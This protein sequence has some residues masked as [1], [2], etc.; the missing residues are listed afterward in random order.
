V[1]LDV[2]QG[3]S[4][5][6]FVVS[7]FAGI[8][9]EVV[10]S[11]GVAR[12]TTVSSG[13]HADVLSG[14]VVSGTILEGMLSDNGNA[15]RTIVISGGEQFVDYSGVA[16]GTLVSSGGEELVYSKGIASGTVVRG[17]IEFVSR[18]GDAIG[19]VVSSGGKESVYY[20]GV[21]SGSIVAK[22]VKSCFI[23]ALP[24]GRLSEVELRTFCRAVMLLARWSTEVGLRSLGKAG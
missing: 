4:I 2:Y 6:G 24:A 10:Y 9:E 3:G 5:S 18:G 23:L 8:A 22:A 16:R 20:G 11:G 15:W 1:S 19:T 17:G 21:T 13:G 12:A 7:N 14:G